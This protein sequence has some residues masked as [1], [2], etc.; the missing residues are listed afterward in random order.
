MLKVCLLGFRQLYFQVGYFPVKEDLVCVDAEGHVRV[1]M[2][3][4]LSNHN[5]VRKDVYNPTETLMVS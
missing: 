3:A 2:N 1:W 5:P 4:N